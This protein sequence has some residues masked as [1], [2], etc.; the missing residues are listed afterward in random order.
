MESAGKPTS[1]PKYEKDANYTIKRKTP[2][3]VSTACVSGDICNALSSVHFYC[4][5]SVLAI[6]DLILSQSSGSIQFGQFVLC[7]I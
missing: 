1:E 3:F 6:L 2:G 7:S 4:W 5:F